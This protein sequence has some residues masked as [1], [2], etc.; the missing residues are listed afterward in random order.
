MGAGV[1][2]RVD[3]VAAPHEHHRRRAEGRLRGRVLGQVG[4]R[5][6]RGELLRPLAAAEG[7]GVH[8]VAVLVDHVATDVRT[9]GDDRV[10]DEQ[11]PERGIVVTVDA[12]HGREG[13]AAQAD[14]VDDAVEAGSRRA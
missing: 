7:V 13:E 6:H 10:A 1:L 3:H 12:L 2:E 11:A 9:H 4:D 5:Q 14:D 8:A